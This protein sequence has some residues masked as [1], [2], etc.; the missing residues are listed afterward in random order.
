MCWVC[1]KLNVVH[2]LLVYA[3]AVNVLGGNLHTVQRNTQALVVASREFGLEVIADKTKYVVMSGDQNAGRSHNI[4][5]DISSFERVEQFSY[6][7]TIL[8]NLNSVQEEIKG[9]LNS[10]NACYLN[11]QNL[12]SSSLLSKN[13]KKH[14]TIMLHVVLCGRGTFSLTLREECRFRL[15]ENRVLRRISCSK[16]DEVTGEWRRLHIEELTGLYCSPNVVRVIKSRRMRWAVRV[17]R[18]W[19]T[20]QVLTGLGVET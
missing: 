4:K 13:I 5:F 12:L 15:S 2:Q 19:E 6:L 20:G 11:V 14:R 16:R 10:W 9:R 8:T 18:V 17:A 7:G 1:L 3:D